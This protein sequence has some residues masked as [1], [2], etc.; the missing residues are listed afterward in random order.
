MESEN[1]LTTY[2]PDPSL[3]N[4]KLNFQRT[5]RFA[6]SGLFFPVHMTDIELK[7]VVDEAFGDLILSN[8]KI[9]KVF[10]RKDKGGK[11]IDFRLEEAYRRP[12]QIVKKTMY[13]FGLNANWKAVDFFEH[14]TRGTKG[15]SKVVGGKTYYY[16]QLL[17]EEYIGYRSD[18]V[19]YI[20]EQRQRQTGKPAVNPIFCGEEWTCIYQ[21][22]HFLLYEE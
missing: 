16:P 11:G 19:D 2:P 13:T 8:T 22:E 21:H 18:V 5:E 12:H 15:T 14:Q 17:A 1:R 7:L 3:R 4:L 9:A 10:V 6:G 20:Y